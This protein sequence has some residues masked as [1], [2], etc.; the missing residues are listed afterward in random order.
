MELPDLRAY[1]IRPL[2]EG[3]ASLTIGGVIVS[4]QPDLLLYTTNGDICGAVKLHFSKSNILME[5]GMKTVA[6][7]LR[8]Y[9]EGIGWSTQNSTCI[10]IDIFAAKYA[11]APSAYKQTMKRVEAAC[12]EIALHWGDV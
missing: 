2:E 12:R 5:E 10:S 8:N 4:V 11:M 6:T 3:G 1:A 7:V 9:L